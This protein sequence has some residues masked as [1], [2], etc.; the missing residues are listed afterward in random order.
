MY[1]FY[2]LV[3]VL[4]RPPVLGLLKGPFGLVKVQGLYVRQR[5]VHNQLLLTYTLYK[6]LSST[7]RTNLLNFNKMLA[8]ITIIKMM[9]RM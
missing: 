5:L 2:Y 6:S 3:R 7:S 9:V 4:W 8:K 1:D